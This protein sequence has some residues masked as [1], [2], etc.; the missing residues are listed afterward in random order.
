MTAV[1]EIS[2]RGPLTPDH[3]IHTKRTPMV[4]GRRRGPIG[5]RLRRA[6]P[7]VLRAQHLGRLAD[8]RRGAALGRLARARRGVV[9]RDRPSAPA[10]SPTSCAT[11][12]APRAGPRRSAAGPRCPSVTS[13]TSSTGSWSKPS[14]RSRAGACR[15]KARSRWSPARPAASARRASTRCARKAPPSSRSTSARP[16]P[17]TGRAPTCSGSR[18]ISRI[19]RRSTRPLPRRSSLRR[20]RHRGRQRRHFPGQRQHR[21]RSNDDAWQ[22][23]LDINLTSQMYLFRAATPLPAAGARAGH[24][25]RRFQERRR[26]GAGC[27]RLLGVESGR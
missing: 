19:A 8:A 14:S 5:R 24:R 22:R 9:R 13:S 2:R 26:A 3:V 18:Q 21:R 6:L 17:A 7:R 15:S 12:C 16:S 10:S 11:P 1:A 27:R 25:R 23:T 4:L 20:P